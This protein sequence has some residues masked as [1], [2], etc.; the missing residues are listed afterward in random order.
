MSLTKDTVRRTI[1]ALSGQ[2]AGNNLV[3]VVGLIGGAQLGASGVIAKSTNGDF[4]LVPDSGGAVGT[5]RFYFSDPTLNARVSSI[6][7]FEVKGFT[8]RSPTATETADALVTG[9]NYDT[10]LNQWYVTVAMAAIGTG[11]WFSTPSSIPTGYVLGIRMAVS[12]Q[13]AANSI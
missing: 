9:Y 7:W 3:G 5:Y 13:Q 12:Y 11:A 4:T 10:T 2:T 1:I 6:D 8:P